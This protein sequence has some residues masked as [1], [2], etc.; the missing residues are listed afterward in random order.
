MA[1]PVYKKI[2]ELDTLSASLDGNETL[3]IV[4]AGKTYRRTW[5]N[6]FGS[7]WIT[8]LLGAFSAFKAPDANHADDADTVGG[9]STAQLHAAGSLTGALNLAVIPA[10]LTG[11]NAATA[12]TSAACSGNA[13]TATL[14][15]TATNALACSGNAATATTA[16]SCSG[17]AATATTA[18]SC[19][20]NAASATTAAACSGNAATA[21]TASSCSGNSATATT[22]GSATNASNIE[23]TEFDGAG[24]IAVFNDNRATAQKLARGP[25]F[26]PSATVYATNI[27]QDTVADG[28]LNYYGNGLPA[29]DGTQHGRFYYNTG[30][31]GF[32]YC[33]RTKGT[34]YRWIKIG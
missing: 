22:A 31:D 13:A 33:A 29:A 19:S 20:G 10:E 2:T 30:D 23:S 1:E 17:N 25:Y 4:K 12:T 24:N 27:L 5:A 15:A 26:G 32:Y 7:G 34:S 6:F 16:A 14:A 9:E 3:P 21:T 28:Q 18:A 11:K 8:S